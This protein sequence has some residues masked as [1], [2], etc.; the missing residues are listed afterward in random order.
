VSTL[1]LKKVCMLGD[2]AVGKTSLVRRFVHESFDDRYLSS[3]G[4]KVSRK[5]V[6]LREDFGISLLVWDLAG[7][8]EFTG[9]QTNYLRGAAGAL[10]VCDLTRA[11]TLPSIEKYAE[12]LRDVTPQAVVIVVGNKDDLIG[13]VEVES[14][15]LT[16][17][18]K[19]IDAKFLIT[20][21]KSGAGVEDSF[22]TLAKQMIDNA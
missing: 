14:E 17:L 5:E 11:D 3:I 9:L 12:R 2:F 10:L 7:G 21:A 22:H 6:T 18:A 16:A 1:I 20:S 15:Q 13:Q 8:E 4:V 19:K